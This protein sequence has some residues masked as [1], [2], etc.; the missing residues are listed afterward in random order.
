[1]SQPRPLQNVSVIV[2]A[3][4]RS[5]RMGDGQ[6]KQYIELGGKPMLQHVLEKL[7]SLGPKELVVAV[8]PDDAGFEKLP[9]SAACRAVQ[10]GA[11]RADSVQLGLAALNAGDD[12]WVMVHDAARPCV[13]VDDILRLEKTVGDDGV[14]GILAIPVV[15]TVKRSDD[16]ERI[17]GTVSRDGLWLAQTPQLFRRGMLIRALQSAKK[18]GLEVTDEA[19]AVEWLGFA[20]L[21]VEGSRENIKVTTPG[22][23][24]LAEYYLR[25]QE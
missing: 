7:L 9:A 24:A 21:L 22:D 17:D 23:I 6:R 8:A 15:E 19:A 14:G 4:G 1:M 10:G 25:L 2:P 3:A 20:P 11:S 5:L 16:N 12:D 18:E 13:S